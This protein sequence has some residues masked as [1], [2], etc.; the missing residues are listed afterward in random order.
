[1]FVRSLI[2]YALS[3]TVGAGAIVHAKIQWVEQA[4]QETTENLILVGYT[5]R[6]DRYLTLRN[7]DI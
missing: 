7:K 1:M 6:P 2:I 5:R 3:F 4:L